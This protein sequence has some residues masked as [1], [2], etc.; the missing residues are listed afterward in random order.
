MIELIDD[1]HIDNNN[2]QEIPTIKSEIGKTTYV[3]GI[4]FSKTSKETLKDKI[5]R[6]VLQDVKGK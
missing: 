1:K 6:M 4:H 2:K 3:V 5:K